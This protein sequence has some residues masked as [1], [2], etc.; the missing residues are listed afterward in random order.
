VLG[1]HPDVHRR[2]EGVAV[3]EIHSHGQD[4]RKALGCLPGSVIE[5]ARSIRP[6]W[7]RQDLFAQAIHG[8]DDRSRADT[9]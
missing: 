1:Q 7:L 5:S 2:N 9:G 3:D 6:S 4:K 8:V